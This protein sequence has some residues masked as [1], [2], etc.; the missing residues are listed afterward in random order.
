SPGDCRGCLL[1]ATNVNNQPLLSRQRPVRDLE[2]AKRPIAGLRMITL[3]RSMGNEFH[4]SSHKPPTWKQRQC[5]KELG[6]PHEEVHSAFMA[7]QL[8]RENYDKWAQ[9]QPTDDQKK[10]LLRYG[11]WKYGMN[12]GEAAKAIEKL[13]AM[14]R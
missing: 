8:I 13:L 11:V 10:L 14:L 12:R 2:T 4:H 7:D 5:L 3:E 6:I 9:L 1:R